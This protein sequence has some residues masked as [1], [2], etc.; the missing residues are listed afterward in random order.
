M[1]LVNIA[2]EFPTT[3]WRHHGCSYLQRSGRS[4]TKRTCRMWNLGVRPWTSGGLSTNRLSSVRQGKS[5]GLHRSYRHDLPG[6][7]NIQHH[8]INSRETR[9]CVVCSSA[10]RAEGRGGAHQVGHGPNH[11]EKG[12]GIFLFELKSVFNFNQHREKNE[13]RTPSILTR[14]FNLSNA[15]TWQVFLTPEEDTSGQNVA[16]NK[17]SYQDW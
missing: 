3:T 12:G 16:P 13:S 9:Q 11:L 4:R 6:A 14:V 7:V 17:S 15:L 10:V 8:R 2:Y 5:C 1:I